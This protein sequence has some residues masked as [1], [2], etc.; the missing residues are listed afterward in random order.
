MPGTI[1]GTIYKP[2]TATSVPKKDYK[3]ANLTKKEQK[4]QMV[5]PDTIKVN[6]NDKWN[7]NKH[8]YEY[9]TI[10]KLSE[11]DIKDYEKSAN[12]NTLYTAQQAGFEWVVHFAVTNVI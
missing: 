3:E 1:A 10:Y 5:T 12:Y 8:P 9:N 2:R 11:A 6:T 4:I 7:S